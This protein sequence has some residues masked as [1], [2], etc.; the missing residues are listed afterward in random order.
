MKGHRV[1]VK[2]T[3]ISH[4]AY[5]LTRLDENHNETNLASVSLFNQK[6]LAKTLHNLK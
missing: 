5:H 2:V 1:K 3:K 4:A 6:L